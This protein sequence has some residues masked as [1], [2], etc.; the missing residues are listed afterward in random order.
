MT[1]KRDLRVEVQ[2]EGK[3]HTFQGDLEATVTPEGMLILR[4]YTSGPNTGA[5]GETVFCAQ[6][7]GWL[8]AALHPVAADDA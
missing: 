1:A 4:D 3:M 7:G 5:Y 6:S 2:I 8:S